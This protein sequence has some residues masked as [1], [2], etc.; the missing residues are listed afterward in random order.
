MVYSFAWSW[1]KGLGEKPKWILPSILKVKFKV[2][3]LALPLVSVYISS[4]ILISDVE[5]LKDIF[6]GKVSKPDSWLSSFRTEKRK[7]TGT[8]GWTLPR[9]FL[10]GATAVEM[11][12]LACAEAKLGWLCR[13]DGLLRRGQGAILA[14][15]F[16]VVTVCTYKQ[17]WAPHLALIHIDRVTW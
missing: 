14:W 17:M 3:D 10:S 15:A 16:I 13:P 8:K 11:I 5:Y 9:G 6:L 2:P 7:L 1:S 4:D 12:G